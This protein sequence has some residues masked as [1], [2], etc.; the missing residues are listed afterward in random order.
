MVGF[1]RKEPFQRIE[2][3]GYA[4]SGITIVVGGAL[5]IKVGT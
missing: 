4:E 1:S 3:A 5:K 2:G